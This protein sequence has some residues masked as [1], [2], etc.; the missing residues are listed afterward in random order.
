M[1]T[2]PDPAA[3]LTGAT[4]HGA[5]GAADTHGA[6]ATRMPRGLYGL[7]P[8][9]TDL[10]R[11]ADAISQAAQGG[12]AA[13]QWRR[14]TLSPADSR[15]QAR[16]IAALCR[17]LGVRFLINDDWRMAAELDADGV[18]LG[19]DDGLLH[20]ARHALGPDAIIG[21]SCYDQPALASQA[22]ADGA[23]YV[24]FGAVYPSSTKPDAVRAT[25]AHIAQGA[26]L[27]RSAAR[28][29]WRP[30]VVAIG[31]ITP[32]NAAPVVQAGADSLALIQGLF[33]APDIVQAARQCLAL[34]APA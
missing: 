27:A 3:P 26:A 13:L 22:I 2:H 5:P 23:D 12:M 1:T 32:D 11:L 19:R 18:H 6:I 17:S 15:A 7:T 14:K 29:G 25:S 10:D 28:D 4:L 16:Q 8:E 31:G 9:W 33:E 20:D 34:Y 30:A 24:A 21:R